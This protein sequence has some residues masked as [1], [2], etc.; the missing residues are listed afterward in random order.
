[1]SALEV[2]TGVSMDGRALSVDTQRAAAEIAHDVA[3]DPRAPCCTVH[4]GLRLAACSTWSRL[5]CCR[6]ALHVGRGRQA[7]K[8]GQPDDAGRA[9]FFGISIFLFFSTRHRFSKSER[10]LGGIAF[11]HMCPILGPTPIPC[12]SWLEICPTIQGASPRPCRSVH[13]AARCDLTREAIEELAPRLEDTAN[14]RK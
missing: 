4:D 8:A 3:L 10:E 11:W 13:I 9:K 2:T 5:A 7:G 1:M 12:G 6:R 14:R